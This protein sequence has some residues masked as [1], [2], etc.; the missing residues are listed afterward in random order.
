MFA[1][2]QERWSVAEIKETR[3]YDANGVKPAPGGKDLYHTAPNDLRLGV[4]TPDQVC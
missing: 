1:L 4:S 2:I 3:L